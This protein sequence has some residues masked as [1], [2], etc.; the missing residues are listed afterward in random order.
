MC[1]YNLDSTLGEPVSERQ[2]LRQ[3]S[4]GLERIARLRPSIITVTPAG[5]FL[6][7]EE[8]PRRVA[9]KIADVVKSLESTRVLYVESR[10]VY[11]LQAVEDGL[12]ERL[13]D[14]LAPVELSVGI[15]LESIDDFVRNCIIHKGISLRAVEKAVKALRE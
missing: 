13:L 14:K 12:I 2:L 7:P 3:L 10:A 1:G 11:V 5:S 8:L 4:S 15:G 9:L 6:D